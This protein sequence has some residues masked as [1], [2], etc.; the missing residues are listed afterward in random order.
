[1][2]RAPRYTVA[3]AALFFLTSPSPAR[4]QGTPVIYACL[5]PGNGNVS[6][7][8]ATEECRP[9]ETRVQW[10]VVGQPGPQGPRGPQGETGPQGP[11]GAV[12]PQGPQ[13]E[14][15]ATG[16]Q[17]PI[18]PAGPQ[19]PI[20]ETG[21]AGPE[22]PA[23]PQGPQGAQGPQGISGFV[24]VLSY[25]RANSPFTIAG[26]TVPPGC[27]TAPHTAGANEVA[28]LT[29]NVTLFN[30]AMTG[31]VFYAPVY[32]VN[33]VGPNYPVNNFAIETSQQGTS[34]TVPHQAVVTLAEGSTYRFRTEVRSQNVAF[35]VAEL[36]C[37]GQVTIAKQ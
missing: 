14:T 33:G 36:V 21:E 16:A 3:A 18:G 2:F 5:N 27:E 32:T 8:G 24:R 10:N 1:V 15:G 29:G 37:R 13:G 22:G 9:N 23:G 4:A 34:A 19:G 31:T 20:G 7:V 26:A 6:V 28:I 12:G 17:G 35:T 25:E 11:Q 30:A